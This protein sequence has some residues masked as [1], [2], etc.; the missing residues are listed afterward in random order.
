MGVAEPARRPARDEIV[1]RLVGEHAD[2]AV[3]QRHVDMAADA[4]DGAARERGL[5]RHDR[6]EAGEDVGEGDAD[7]LRPAGGIAGEIHDSA[8]A[9][10]HE[11]VARARGIGPVWPKPVIEQ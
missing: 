11:V 9:L 1:Q 10:D 6:I 8:H 4:G 5:D 2:L 7:L 3:H